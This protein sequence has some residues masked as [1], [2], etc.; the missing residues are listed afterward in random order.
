MRADYFTCNYASMIFTI[1]CSDQNS[2]GDLSPCLSQTAFSDQD[3]TNEL[4]YM[5]L[6]GNDGQSPHTL[7]KCYTTSMQ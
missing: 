2:I 4:S 6:F 3:L 5:S 1:A 7:G